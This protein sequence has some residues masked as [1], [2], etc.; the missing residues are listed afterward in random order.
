MGGR[1]RRRW[2]WNRRSETMWRQLSSNVSRVDAAPSDSAPQT[3]GNLL[4]AVD[5]NE[6]RASAPLAAQSLTLLTFSFFSSFLFFVRVTVAF[7]TQSCGFV[8]G[9]SARW[10]RGWGAQC[11][12]A[13]RAGGV[14]CRVSS[15]WS[16]AAV[17]FVCSLW[18]RCVGRVDGGVVGGETQTRK[19]QRVQRAS[20]VRR[21]APVD[22]AWC[23]SGVSRQMSF[24]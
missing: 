22:V 4:F 19:R 24:G 15:T 23:G 14:W 9:A 7:A 5:L 17:S 3:S 18:C 8:R 13:A 20:G 21:A 6:R 16:G 12:A 2:R 10:V 1:R 11:G